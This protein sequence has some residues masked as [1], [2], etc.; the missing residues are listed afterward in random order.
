M[1][2]HPRIITDNF[3]TYTVIHNVRDMCSQLLQLILN[4]HMSSVHAGNVAVYEQS[5]N[6]IMHMDMDMDMVPP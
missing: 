1:L 5:L 4:P 2:H 3:N 6:W